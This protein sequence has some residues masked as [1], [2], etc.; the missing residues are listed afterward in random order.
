M[1]PA[2]FSSP[3]LGEALVKRLVAYPLAALCA[4]AIGVSPAVGGTPTH[5]SGKSFSAFSIGF[6]QAVGLNVDYQVQVGS[7]TFRRAGGQQFTIVTD[8][9]FA[10]FSI[11]N[12]NGSAFGFGCWLIPDSDVVLNSDLSAS[13]TFDSSDPR[14]TECPGDPVGASGLA[15]QGLVDNLA[16]PI[17]ID[18]TWSPTSPVTETRTTSQRM[19]QP[20]AIVLTSGSSQNVDA[21]ASGPVSGAFADPSLPFSA[22]PQGFFGGV[23]IFD[24]Q[25]QETNTGDFCPGP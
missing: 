18:A 15:A 5:L 11:S 21:V 10:D 12:F 20:V 19:C 6:D 4:L 14:V 9:L 2:P 13:L 17:Q 3:G 22:N 16:G 24:G 23:S 8:V 1:M 25:T 7:T